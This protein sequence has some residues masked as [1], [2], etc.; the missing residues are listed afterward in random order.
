MTAAERMVLVPGGTSRM[1]S[2]SHYSEEAPVHRVAADAFRIDRCEVTNSD[3]EAFVQATAYITVAERPVDAADCPGAPPE[4]QVPGGAEAP[5]GHAC[6]G[7]DPFAGSC[8]FRPAH[9][10]RGGQRFERRSPYELGPRPWA[11]P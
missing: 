9:P 1:G 2:D 7:R 5:E 4:N 3:F 6:A 11:G 10:W 8:A